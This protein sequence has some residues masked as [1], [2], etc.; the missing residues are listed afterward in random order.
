MSGHSKWHEIKR[1]KAKNDQVR[2]RLFSRLAREIMVAARLGGGVPENNPR[3]RMAI[4]N[5]KSAG[6]PAENIE[7]AIKKGTGELEGEHLEEVTYEGYAPGGVAL[8]IEVMTGNR[9]RTVSELRHVFNRLGGSLGE[10]GCVSWLFEKKGMITVD[11]DTADEDT[12]LEIALE[13]GAEDMQVTGDAYEI[14]TTPEDFEAVR[15]ALLERGITPSS[16]ELTLIPQSTVSLD[17]ETAR[18]VLRLM[19]ALEELEDVQKVYANLDIPAEVMA[20]LESQL[21][22]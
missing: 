6:M 21:A 15:Q 7:R 19:D 18:K 13:A 4:E 20:A 9:N 11:L 2:G 12:M 3:L 17:L 22:A 16:A 1:K 8:M 14:I 5:A 10:S